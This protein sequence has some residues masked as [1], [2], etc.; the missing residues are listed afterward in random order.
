[1]LVEGVTRR[2]WERVPQG[3]ANLSELSRKSGVPYYRLYRSSNGWRELHAD[4]F[5]SL[6]AALGVDP[7]E[8]LADEKPPSEQAA[9][10]RG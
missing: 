9:D 3:N 6:C 5:L 8:F 2:L 4:E 7:G 10:E 1:M